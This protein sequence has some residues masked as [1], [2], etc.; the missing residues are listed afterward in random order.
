MKEKPIIIT[1]DN[2]RGKK[3]IFTI[4]SDASIDIMRMSSLYDALNGHAETFS[5]INI[6]IEHEGITM[7]TIK[8]DGEV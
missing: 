7:K 3:I 5:N 2:Y 8:K 1:I 6:N 4:P